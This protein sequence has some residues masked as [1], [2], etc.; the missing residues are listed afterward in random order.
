[1]SSPVGHQ[2]AERVGKV[3]TTGW[4]NVAKRS[5]EGVTAGDISAM[6]KHR[7]GAASVLGL[8]GQVWG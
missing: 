7:A 1:M 6:H 5:R 3:R 2:I 4:G 8:R